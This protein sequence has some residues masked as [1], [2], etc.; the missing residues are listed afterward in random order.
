MTLKGL[1]QVMKISVSGVWL[2]LPKEIASELLAKATS[3]SL[4]AG[5]TLFAAGDGGD[6][7]YRLN[8]GVLKVKLASQQGSERIIAILPEGSIVGDLSMIDG[9][10]RSASV[11][12]LTECQ[13]AFISQK[14]FQECAKRH[15]E[16]YRFLV[17]VLAKRLRETDHTIA[18]LAFLTARGRVANALIELSE[19]LGRKTP[20]GRVMISNVV[21]QK[22]LAAMAGVSRENTNRILQA[23]QRQ[24][25][26]EKTQNSYCIEDLAR[27]AREMDWQELEQ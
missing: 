3:R 23:W 14:S 22:D 13:L 20:D 16:I 11:V 8:K 25:L 12:A 27:L 4:K 5:Q 21:S 17:D 7:C 6:G 9:L 18:A 19:T 2:G 10:E 24:K 26:V 1:G 15:P